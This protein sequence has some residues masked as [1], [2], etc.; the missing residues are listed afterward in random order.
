MDNYVFSC[1][2]KLRKGYTTSSCAAA[3]AK[4]AVTMLL[5]QKKL[6][7]V[8][9]LTP[10]QTPLTLKIENQEIGEAFASCSIRKFSGD[11]PDITNGIE[12]FS[13]AEKN[14]NKGLVITGGEGIGKVTKKGLL[15]PVGEYAINPAPMEMIKSAVLEACSDFEVPANIKITIFAPEGKEI[16]KKT[17][18]PKLGI[19][20]GI[21]ILGTSGIVFPMSS[22]AILKTIELEI[23]QKKAEGKTSL[24]FCPGNYGENFI[25]NKTKLSPKTAVKCSNFVGDSLDLAYEM[26]F[27]KA[28]LVG[29]IGKLVKLAGGIMN[30]HSRN[31]DCRMEI[32]ASSAAFF[33]DDIKLLRNILNQKTTLSAVKLLKNAG[34]LE[35]TFEKITSNAYEKLNQRF[36]GDMEI[37]LIMFTEED[38]ILG[39][40][41]GAD[42]LTKKI[43]FEENEK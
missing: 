15:V 29:H 35:Q 25:K 12:I 17:Y 22:E 41:K 21:S 27:K 6:E 13:L 8:F 30:T 3:G 16:A 9:L 18:N 1:G 19:E 24:L 39:K 14:E 26:G 5:S 38:G 34:I 43:L 40:S 31:G 23:R 4:A 28:L 37:E 10:N 11:D 2:K 33:T 20:G 36:F 7:T 32:I 42:S